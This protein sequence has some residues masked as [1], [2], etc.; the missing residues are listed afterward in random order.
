MRLAIP[1]DTNA[2]AR[3]WWTIEEINVAS[4]ELFAEVVMVVL[5]VVLVVVVY[6]REAGDGA[7]GPFHYK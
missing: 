1:F 4:P 2:N 6:G 7:D 5:A 3:K